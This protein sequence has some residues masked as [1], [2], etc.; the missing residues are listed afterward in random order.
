[1]KTPETTQVLLNH[2]MYLFLKGK[3]KQV[4][5][6]WMFS[7]VTFV[8]SPLKIPCLNSYPL[9]SLKYCTVAI[10]YLGLLDLLHW[11]LMIFCVPFKLFIFTTK[12]LSYWTPAYVSYATSSYS[13][14]NSLYYCQVH[15][16]SPLLACLTVANVRFCFLCPE[17]HPTPVL[18]PFPS[19]NPSDLVGTTE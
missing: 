9:D 3:K 2:F 11:V 17:Q 6:F 4:T 1:M 13:F 12:S 15:L 19:S 18:S 8:T 5:K 16:L 7:L 10:H 14:A